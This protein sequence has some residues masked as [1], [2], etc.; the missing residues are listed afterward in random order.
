MPSVLS[1][2]RLRVTMT[3]SAAT[4]VA[5]ILAH[6]DAEQICHGLIGRVSRVT[7]GD[8]HVTVL[9]STATGF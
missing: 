8:R 2:A 9:P 1:Q 3:I 4:V 5:I 7:K 6:C